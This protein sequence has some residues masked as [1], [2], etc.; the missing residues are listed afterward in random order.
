M[1]AT[2]LVPRADLE[3]LTSA[4]TAFAA[5]QR[6]TREMGGPAPPAYY[7][8]EGGP[9][10]QLTPEAMAAELDALDSAVIAT[11]R[12]LGWRR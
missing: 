5:L 8:V 1:A 7:G 9:A 2:V 6:L 12:L 3:R 10:V 4:A 11:R